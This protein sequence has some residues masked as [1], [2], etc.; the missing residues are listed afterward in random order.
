[1]AAAFGGDRKTITMAVV[2]PTKSEQQLNFSIKGVVL[3]GKANVT[4]VVGQ[5]P[6]IEGEEHTVDGVPATI[7]YRSH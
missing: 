5:K 6:A 4:V 2:N 1:M 7:T 3:S